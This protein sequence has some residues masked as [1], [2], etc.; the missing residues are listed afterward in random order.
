MVEANQV[1]PTILVVDD[2]QANLVAIETVLS[3]FPVRLLLANGGE[4]AL[5]VLLREPQIPVVALLDV[6]MPGMDG[7]ELASLLRSAH[8]TR[9]MP[10]VFVSAVHQDVSHINKG[11]DSGAIDFLVKP[12]DEQVLRAKV[13]IFLELHQSRAQLEQ[14]LEARTKLTQNLKEA[15]DR[16]ND[17]QRIAKIGSWEQDLITQT[18]SWSEEVF[19]L[20]ELNTTQAPNHENLL[21]RVH[22]EDRD[23]I[24]EA[25]AAPDRSTQDITYRLLIDSRI[26]YIHEQSRIERDKTGCALRIRAT[27]QDVTE[28][29]LASQQ[30]R[31]REY[32]FRMLF[33][34]AIV[35]IATHEIILNE[36]GEAVDYRFLSANPAFNVHTGLKM[37]DVL[38]KCATEVLPG[39]EST[40]L[41]ELYGK[42]VASGE[43]ITVEQ[44]YEPFDKHYLINAYKLDDKS[45]AVTLFDMSERK[46]AEEALRQAASVFEYTSEGIVIT[47]LKGDILEV[48][49]AFSEITGYSREEVLGRNASLLRSDKQDNEFFSA[50]WQ[51]LQE[52]GHWY[53]E[54]WNQ[55]KNGQVYAELLTISAVRDEHEEPYRYIAL[56]SDITRIKE[57][58]QQLEHIAHYDALTHLPNRL[59]LAD[60]LQQ[61]LMQAKRYGH[62]VAV[63]YLDLDGF[64]AVNDTHGH[65]AGDHLLVE[66]SG[67][68]KLALRNSDTLSRLGGDEFVAVLP[69]LSDANVCG[70]IF[71]RLLETASDPVIFNGKELHVSAS[72]GVS[73]FPQ[74]DDVDADQI[75]RQADQAMYLAKQSGK[76]RYHIFDTEQDRNVRS[77]HANLEQIRVAITNS[78]FELFYQ[79]KVNMRTGAVLGVEALIRWRHP[80]RGMIPPGL[81]LPVIDNHPLL[82]DLGNWVLQNALNQFDSWYQQGLHLPISINV[83]GIQL[84]PADFVELLQAEM[85]KHPCLSPGDLQLEVLESSALDDIEQVSRVLGTCLSMGV[86]VALDDFGTGYSSLSYLKRLP[87]E[88]LKIDQSFVRDMLHDTDDLS[89]IEGIL[90]LAKAFGREVIAEGVETEDHGMVLINLGCHLGQGY[91]IAR[92]MPADEVLGWIRSWRPPA[93]W[94]GGQQPF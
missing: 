53:G 64:K 22:P 81:F 24:K 18:I 85:A 52:K 13:K 35:G 38:G 40:P 43:P 89:I 26:K 49:R 36:Q 6:Q 19:R 2:V 56:F 11:Y 42:V 39:I 3:D 41:I 67:R 68:M 29:K 83:D 34:N 78:E 30:L 20:F 8:K 51:T 57:H 84:K 47:D 48:N 46:Q 23:W 90:G 28:Q 60:R 31:E 17:A 1:L 71:D 16:L 7:Y 54:I 69:A 63:V 65:E 58:Q 4:K 61:A 86:S 27:V 70:P 94:G 79:P 82:I 37:S 80:D 10:I 9:Q 62:R 5:E 14:T 75:M 73:F 32:A 93:S 91:A 76:N 33:D 55:R 74:V 92:P 77:R 50:M 72:I 88:L 59:L 25:H 45:F 12:I 21:Q 44:Y 66:V 87:V 15:A